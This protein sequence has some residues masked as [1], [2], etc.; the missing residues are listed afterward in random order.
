MLS[1][2]QGGGVYHREHTMTR[3]RELQARAAAR[4][5]ELISTDVRSSH[6]QTSHS[7]PRASLARN[8]DLVTSVGR[9]FVKEAG[10]TW[11]QD[12][13]APIAPWL[14]EDG[15]DEDDASASVTGRQ[16]Y[17]P[18]EL[19]DGKFATV[20]GLQLHYKLVEPANVDAVDVDAPVVVMLHGFNASLF[21][22]RANA[23]EVADRTGLRVVL[24]DRP[25]FGLS[26]RPTAWGDGRD[27]EFDPYEP[28]GGARLA[29]MLVREAL[30]FES[31]KL[32]LVGHSAGSLTALLMHELAP[33]AVAAMIFVAP[34]L[35]TTP[36]NSFQ[37]RATFGQQL[38]IV[39]GR[40]IMANDE[41]G[42]RYI[43]RMITKQRKDL[44]ENGLDYQPHPLTSSQYDSQSI[45]GIT[46]DWS[47]AEEAA[48]QEAVDGYLRPLKTEGWEM[49]ALLNLRSFWLPSS[50]DYGRIGRDVPIQIVAGERDPLTLG[51]KTLHE[52]LTLQKQSVCEYVEF[53]DTGHVVM[54]VK[55]VEFNDAVSTFVRRHVV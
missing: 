42:V 5:W 6:A 4:R 19:A 8:F 48:L 24:M 27:L 46:E 33:D 20:A 39:L 54:E 44:L 21:S 23:Q 9:Q 40:A 28:A 15:D 10:S 34:A 11:V 22:W 18:Q 2:S 53:E 52:I 1:L 31:N 55:P 41:A 26:D 45:D 38:R 7:P 30:G 13:L 36:E 50:Y 43:R 16:V 49:G 3:R 47:A 29:L 37:R 25:P 32:V 35:P 14:D 17:D 12:L 51:A